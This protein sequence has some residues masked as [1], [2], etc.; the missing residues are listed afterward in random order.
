M[1]FTKRPNKNIKNFKNQKYKARIQKMIFKI[2][3][4]LFQVKKEYY[5]KNMMIQKGNTMN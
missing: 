4:I 1:D 2:N 3:Q 5:K